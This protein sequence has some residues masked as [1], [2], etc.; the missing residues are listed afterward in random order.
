MF[1][2]PQASDLDGE[3]DLSTCSNVTEYQA[4]RNYGFQIHVWDLAFDKIFLK[5][6][7]FKARCMLEFSW[8][9]KVEVFPFLDAGGSPYSVSHDSRDTEKLDAGHHEE[10]QTLYCP[11]C[12]KVSRTLDTLVYPYS[13]IILLFN[14]LFKLER[15]SAG[16]PHLL[17]AV[18]LLS[19]LTDVF[20]G[21]CQ[22][23]Q[24]PT[25][26]SLLGP[27]FLSVTMS[28]PPNKHIEDSWNTQQ[29]SKQINLTMAAVSYIVIGRIIYIYRY[30]ICISQNSCHYKVFV[31][32]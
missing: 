10:C 28:F 8:S 6:F 11:W 23:E 15:L 26:F 22:L 19:V 30:F 31:I 25:Q 5:V 32:C 16:R 7:V 21:I 3:I 14:F 27:D 1:V 29:L 4:Q 9:L 24:L 18:L 12:G 2:S 17:V 13:H 20:A